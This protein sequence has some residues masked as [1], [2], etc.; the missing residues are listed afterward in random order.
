MNKNPQI[1]ALL[2]L[3]Q[4]EDPKVASLAMEQF[5]KLESEADEAIAE[6]QDAENPYLRQRLHQLINIRGRQQDRQDFMR[7]VENSAMPVLEGLARINRLYD[8]RCNREKLRRAKKD[9]R[10]A[11]DNSLTGTAEVASFMREQD[12]TVPDEAVLEVDLYLLDSV[13]EYRFG[14]AVMLCALAQ[15]LGRTCGG[16][17][18]TISLYEGRFCLVDGKNLAL[19]PSDEWGIIQLD[20]SRNLHA[21]SRQDVW[22]AVLSRL[23]LVGLTEGNLRDISLFGDL[24]TAL[25]SE[26]ID[27]FPYPIGQYKPRA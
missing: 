22:M 20:P 2:S 4:D 7:H 13:L 6:N 24:L 1:T 19:D 9:L 25:N 12:F 16:W 14:S 21:C 27:A 5:L 23:L 17:R 10:Q 15:Y 8:S 11:A 18:S 3:L 26:R